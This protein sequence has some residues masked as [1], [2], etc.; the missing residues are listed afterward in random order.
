MK[1]FII[2]GE[3]MCLLVPIVCVCVCVCVCA[4]TH[5]HIIPCFPDLFSWT[6]PNFVKICDQNGKEHALHM[7][8]SFQGK[9]KILYVPPNCF[10]ITKRKMVT[11]KWRKLPN[12]FY[13]S[14]Q[15][16]WHHNGTDQHHVSP[17]R[18]TEDT[19]SLLCYS[20]QKHINWM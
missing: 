4:H 17:D 5:A 6:C 3:F 13:P 10:L 8:V 18:H 20:C 19:A 7:N 1:V 15:N 2:Y 11:C 12:D 14:D 16:K 9:I